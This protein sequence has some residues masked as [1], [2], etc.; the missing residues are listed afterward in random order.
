MSMTTSKTIYRTKYGP[1]MAG[2]HVAPFPYTSQLRH[3]PQDKMAEYCLDQLEML[4][5]QQSTADE[6]AAIIMEPVLGMPCGGCRGEM[7]SVLMR[8]AGWLRGWHVL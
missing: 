3:V 8:C 1:L 6:T 2:V 7:L 4:F 5:K